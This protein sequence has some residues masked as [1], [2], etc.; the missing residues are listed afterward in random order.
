MLAIVIPTILAT[1][2]ASPV[3]FRPRV[4]QARALFCLTFDYSGR[5]EVLVW[6]IPLM[7][8]LLVGGVAWVGAHDLDPRKP[9]VLRR[10]P[11]QSS[12][13]F[14]RLEMAVHLSRPR[15]RQRQSFGRSGRHAD[16]L[17]ADVH[18]RYEQLLRAAARQPDLHHGG[19]DDAPPASGG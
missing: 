7:T 19:N 15:H 9:I 3:W 8:V 6:S 2:G 12:G 17:R 4:E 1:L 13:R 5:L 11:A 18:R 10:A 16:Q 14:P